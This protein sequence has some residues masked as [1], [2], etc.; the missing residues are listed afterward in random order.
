MRLHLSNGRELSYADASGTVR[1]FDPSVKEAGPSAG[2][3]DTDAFNEFLTREGLAAVWAIGGMKCVYSG[4][5]LRQGWGG[6]RVFS[7]LLWRDGDRF[8]RHDN[9]TY[10][11]PTRDQLKTFLA[12]EPSEDIDRA[13]AA[14]AKFIGE[15][16][17][18]TR[19][20]KVPATK[21]RL[22]KTV[23]AKSKSKPKRSTEVRTGKKKKNVRK[24]RRT[25]KR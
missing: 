20:R 19:T 14:L 3:V 24:K 22:K 12:G 25:K 23:R 13:F 18:P 1:F 6:E 15:T 5:R 10:R 8:K 9:T 2:L 7:T 21:R 17:I 16:E 11:K 4:N